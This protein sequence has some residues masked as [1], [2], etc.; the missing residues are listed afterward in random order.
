MICWP[1]AQTALEE[2]TMAMGSPAMYRR[3]FEYEADSHAKVLAS[4]AAVPEAKRSSE[5]YQKTLALMGHIAAA[6][7]LWLYR[8]GVTPEAPREFFPQGKSLSEITAN[9][10]AVQAEWV[11]WLERLT[12]AELDREFEYAALDG[13]RF[14]NRVED[15]LA[16][17]FGHSWYHRGQVAQLVRSLG[18]KPASTDFVYWTRERLDVPPQ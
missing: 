10:T 16:Q 11:A 4:L 15:I 2:V 13:G 7:C 5:P 18:E 17:L 1:L 12:A 14:R 8:F 6:R 9:L 3:W